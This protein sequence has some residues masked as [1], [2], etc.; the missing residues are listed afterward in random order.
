M[1]GS[2]P[3]R[4]LFGRDDQIAVVRSE[5]EG[6]GEGF[7]IVLLTG[8]AGIGKTAI[9]EAGVADGYER[10]YVVLQTRACESEARLSLGGLSD[11]LENVD[12]EVLAGLP[13]PQRRAVE[14][15][16]LWEESG[17]IDPRAL[18]AGF[19][20]IVRELAAANPVLIAIDDDQWLDTASTAA[21]LYAV[22][23]LRNEHAIVLLTR[24]TEGPGAPYRSDGL[25]PD[26]STMPARVS[27]VDLQPLP[28]Y[29]ILRLI[30]HPLPARLGRRVYNMS[31]GNPFFA[32]E[33]AEALRRGDH[34]T[35]SG[36][37]LPVPSSLH[38]LVSARLAAASAGARQAVLVTSLMSNPRIGAIRDILVSTDVERSGAGVD[39]LDDATAAGLIVVRGDHV[40][41]AHPLIGAVS[42][43]EAAPSQTRRLH[44]VL[45][46]MAADIEERGRHRALGGVPPDAAIADELAHIADATADR[47][48][49]AAAADLTEHAWRFTPTSDPRRDER[50]MTAASRYYQA[51]LHDA[52]VALLTPHLTSLPAGPIRA[53]ARA[54]TAQMSYAQV[55]SPLYEQALA[56]ADPQLRAEILAYQADTGV[57]SGT[58]TVTQALQW[59]LEAVEISADLDDHVARAQIVW[60]AAWMEA[61]LGADPEQ[62]LAT[63]DPR[64]L[65]DLPL[66]DHGDRLR[67]L[68]AMWRGDV[69]QAQQLFCELRKLAAERD[70]EWSAS[71]FTL[72][73]F[74]VAIRAGDWAFAAE[75]RS[76]FVDLAAR[77]GHDPTM[78]WRT[79]AAIAAGT[80]DRAL[81]DVLLRQFDEMVT[82]TA[83]ERPQ[84][85]PMFWHHTE[86][87]RAA[88]QAA[89]FDGDAEAAVA[90]LA[91]VA[92]DATAGGYRDPGV[93]PT[94]PDLIEALVKAGRLNDA[95][96]A[97][98]QL[99][100]VAAELD[101]PWA[102]AGA[103]R[104]RGILLSAS[105]VAASTPKASADTAPGTDDAEAALTEALERYR[106]LNL[107]F[108]EAR[109]IV[110]L[111]TLR[112]RQRRFREARTLLQDAADRF[113][114]L[115]AYGLARTARDEAKR[116]GGRTPEHAS[117]TSGLTPTEQQVVELV[118]TGCTNRQVADRLFISVSAV[119]A[120]LTRVYAKF[121]VASRTQLV[122]KLGSDA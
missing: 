84:S 119:E 4:G 72:H 24:R 111:G 39:D 67:A 37:E 46:D 34:P 30:D 40:R 100:A 103:A 56:E 106:D 51:G 1:S 23:R 78:L 55:S 10:G 75:V 81:A 6:A 97:L 8:Q 73:M 21:V 45:A 44:R 74:E 71:V 93:F 41:L 101:H 32:L 77:L 3:D 36:D 68:H 19:L 53:R 85:P 87:R 91:R 60:E 12:P 13:L 88:G 108:D 11:L 64:L 62:R 98:E 28:L 104:A 33:I 58:V 61:L 57:A 18:G 20:S 117:T 54:L 82:L 52:G 96:G 42:R 109:T 118:V 48:G 107:P 35:G 9:W 49:A 102:R 80:G 94:G 112:R 116:V 14:A 121:G 59:T 65:P 7:R 95:Q 89:L 69:E 63:L 79:Q 113:E 17:P 105:T 90:L 76:D 5:I 92:A 122:R 83:A 99:D 26:L 29:A 114:H 2:S 38:A 86:T 25:A 66:H 16:L 47:A 120:H 43:A 31:G 110:A 15:A 70:E 27:T 22:R 115:G 50:L